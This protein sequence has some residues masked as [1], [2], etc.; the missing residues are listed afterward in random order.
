MKTAEEY[1]KEYRDRPNCVTEF[2]FKKA[3]NTAMRE[4]LEEVREAV[5]NYM[6]S[7]GCSCCQNIT[8]HEMHT[9]VLGELLNVDK[10]SD[11]SGYE[12]SKYRTPKTN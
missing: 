6:Q 8:A 5:A 7:E 11:D 4:S 9:K 12:F 2:E 3:I 10:Y 1:Y